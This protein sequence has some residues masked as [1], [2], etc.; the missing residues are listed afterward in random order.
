MLDMID[1]L[2]NRKKNIM[3]DIEALTAFHLF[4]KSDAFATNSFN[5]ILFCTLV[6][7]LG[8]DLKLKELQKL[9]CF[10]CS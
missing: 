7:F 10:G 1:V 6:I 4:E 5:P 3:R 8:V 9:T 2:S